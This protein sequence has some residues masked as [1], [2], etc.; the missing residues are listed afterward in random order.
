M[1]CY[2]PGGGRVPA[3]ANLPAHAPEAISP[4]AGTSLSAQTHFPVTSR[5]E[6][7]MS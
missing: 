1:N 6:K 2:T 4:V 3:S 7:K 5:K